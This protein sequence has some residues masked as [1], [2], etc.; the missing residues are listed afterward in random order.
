MKGKENQKL[1]FG[2]HSNMQYLSLNIQIISK[3]KLT[4]KIQIKM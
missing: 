4:V 3:F 2:N 1:P